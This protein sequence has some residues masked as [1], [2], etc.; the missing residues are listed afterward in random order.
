MR[1]LDGLSGPW[2]GLSL[3][4]GFRLSESIHLTISGG[5]IVG[6]GEDSDGLFEIEGGYD[7]SGA[8]LITRRYSVCHHGS[9][10]EGVPY[11]YRGRWDGDMISG[12]WEE[13]GYAVNGDLFEMWPES[14]ESLSVAELLRQSEPVPA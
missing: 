10:G 9:D 7:A 2:R 13:R 1:E 6:T 12:T 14:G 8:V 3:Q 11:D 5:R 4:E